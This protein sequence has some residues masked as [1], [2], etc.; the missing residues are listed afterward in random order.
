MNKVSYLETKFNNHIFI[1]NQLRISAEYEKRTIIPVKS[2]IIKILYEC[3]RI[4]HDIAY[5]MK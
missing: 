5:T 1:E 3:R 4:F 2:D